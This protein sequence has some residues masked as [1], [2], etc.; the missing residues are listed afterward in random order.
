[1]E[2]YITEFGGANK[3]DGFARIIANPDGGP[4][5]AVVVY[6]EGDLCNGHHAMVKVGMGFLIIEAKWG[7][8]DCASI[9]R[10]VGYYRDECIIK[11][12][13][14]YNNGDMVITD[15]QI[16]EAMAEHLI[17]RAFIKADDYHCKMPHYVIFGGTDYSEFSHV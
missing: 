4:P 10:V 13:A 6:E 12:I 2:C 1:M 14:R 7:N 16:P 11:T 17:D 3:N 9:K 15:N 8:I 5:S